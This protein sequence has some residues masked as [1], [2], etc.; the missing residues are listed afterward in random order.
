[1]KRRSMKE[2]YELY[3]LKR[4]IGISHYP[5][6]A[7]EAPEYPL[8]NADFLNSQPEEEIHMLVYVHIPFCEH[9]CPFCPYHKIVYEEK[10]AEVYVERLLEEIKAYADTPY[11]QKAVVDAVY[12][13]GGTPSCLSEKQLMKILKI[14]KDHLRFGG[15]P[16]IT[17]EGNPHT[18]SQSKMQ[19]L[20]EAG[21]NRISFG[22]QTFEEKMAQFM[23]V[24]HSPKE[25]AEAIKNA[26]TTGF[27]KVSI[28]LMYHLPGQ[29]IE[30]WMS[31]VERAVLS[32]A[33]HITLF[34]FVQI[35][36]SRI[37][38]KMQQE[39]RMVSSLETELKM[40]QCAADF[41]QNQG[42]KQE[43]T[44]DFAKPG[45]ESLYGKLHFQQ[46]LDLLGLGMG[47]FGEVNRRCYINT[48][49]F[50]DYL[51]HVNDGRF[52][53]HLQDYVYREDEIFAVLS[54]GLRMLEV[55]LERLKNTGKN[56]FEIFARQI[57]A[58]TERKLLEIADGKIR[59]TREGILWGNNICKEFYSEAYKKTLPAWQRMEEL[60]RVKR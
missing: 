2:K 14:L 23:E 19:T 54:M 30:A 24:P 45:K 20:K 34:P 44:Y 4:E 32:E 10:Q 9:I 60:A 55:D 42:Y 3:Y 33:D 40:C 38:K 46:H 47:A 39:N 56:V 7:S 25:A 28:D 51:R 29:S 11:I 15:E 50:K 1:M 13:G 8:T 58:L 57:K 41:L 5:M 36:G 17:V 35:P 43:S 31:D 37:C 21:V 6:P 52:P 18:F 49:D 53:I 12:F 48:G 27:E 16:E 22:I 59:L 26:K